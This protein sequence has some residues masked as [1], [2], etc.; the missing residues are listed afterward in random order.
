MDIGLASAIRNLPGK[1][2]PL[3]RLYR[4]F[5][6]DAELAEELGFS[7]VWISEHHSAEDNWNSSPLT[8]LAAT[9]ARTE[10]IRIG[11][12]VLLLSLHNPL[13]IAEEAATVDILSN[14]RLDLAIGAGPMQPECDMFGIEKKETFGRTYEALDFMQR[15]FTEEGPFDYDGKYY[16]YRNVAMRPRGVQTPHPP[17]WMAA[18]GP[19]SIALAAKRGYN[20][21]S[22]LHT[23]LWHTYAGQL[24]E[25]GHRRAD[26][27][28]TSGPVVVHI[29]DTR[30]QAWD[31][32]EKQVHWGVEFYRRRGMDMPLPPAE[33]LRHTPNAGIYAVPFVI[34][35][36]DEVMVKLSRY[37][38][39]PMDQIGLQFR[40]PGMETKHVHRSMRTFAREVMPEI[41][42]WG[43]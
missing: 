27:Q 32:C 39:E 35:T 25:H 20:L 19:Q 37:K 24:E 36:P 41:R 12:Y 40:A 22:A 14:G 1:A 26:K 13:K 10:S 38:N 42:S 28:V 23:P 5:L 7:H 16:R 6:A 29:A 4:D 43:K 9:A 33:Q 18:M 2:E 8:I 3:P 31:E 17:I 11:T 30:D 34:G 15:C 21:A